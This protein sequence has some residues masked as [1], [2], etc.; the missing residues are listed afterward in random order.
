MHLP[1]ERISI[2]MNLVYMRKYSNEADNDNMVRERS[3]ILLIGG[4]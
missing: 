2:S 4:T 3:Y 1:F